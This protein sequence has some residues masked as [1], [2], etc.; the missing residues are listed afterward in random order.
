MARYRKNT[1]IN[2]GGFGVVYRAVRVEDG[3]VVAFKELA[4]TGITDD[5][6]KRFVREVKIQA[7]LDHHNLIQ[8]LGYNLD[9]DPPWFVMPLARTNLE[10]D[11]LFREE[12]TLNIILHVDQTLFSI[13]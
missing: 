2:S 10:I 8:I 13:Y 12:S 4:T 3:E 7:K 5:E 11:G 1:K 9:T 6:R